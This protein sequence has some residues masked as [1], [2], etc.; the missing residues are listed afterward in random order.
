MT[1]ETNY[2]QQ[3]KQNELFQRMSS[4]QKSIYLSFEK[5]KEMDLTTDQVIKN[6]KN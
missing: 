1:K 5:W 3:K 6:G 2:E 4:E